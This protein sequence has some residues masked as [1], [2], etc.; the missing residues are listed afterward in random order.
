MAKIA[1]LTNHY[2]EK[3]WHLIESKELSLWLK[4]GSIQ[5]GDLVIYPKK[6]KEAKE[7]V[8]TRLYLIVLKQK[9]K[10]TK[11]DGKNGK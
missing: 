3:S 9:Q 6:V 2:G 8:K 5:E 1:V 10:I 4:D 11:G 7:T